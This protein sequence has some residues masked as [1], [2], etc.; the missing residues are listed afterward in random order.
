MRHVGIPTAVPLALFACSSQSL[1]LAM[2]STARARYRTMLLK[3]P[4]SFEFPVE[5]RNCLSS[6]EIACLAASL[7]AY[8]APSALRPSSEFLHVAPSLTPTP[9]PLPSR[10]S[11]SFVVV[12]AI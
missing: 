4:G 9:I 8:P 11:G 3:K 10:I 5:T 2:V 6:R 1:D 12:V 7:F